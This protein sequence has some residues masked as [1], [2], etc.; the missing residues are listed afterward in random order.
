MVSTLNERDI[1][2]AMEAMAKDKNLS[3]RKAAKIYNITHTTLMRRMKGITPASE[4]RQKQHKITKIEEEVIIQHIID[5][6]ERGFNPKFISVESMANHILES[7][8]RKRIGKQWAY[9]FV[10][11][12]NI[13]KTHFNHVYDFQRAF[14]K[15]PKLI[16]KWFQLFK[17]IKAKYG[18]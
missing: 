1:V 6:D 5:M 9:R 8:G 4:Y 14:Y 12:Y 7:R 11:R 2:M 13:L 3:L 18:I 15:D 16:N 17:N 10:N